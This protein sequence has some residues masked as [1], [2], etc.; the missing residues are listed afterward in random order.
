M[1]TNNPHT[2]Q[3]IARAIEHLTTHYREQPSLGELAEKANLSEFHFQRLFTEWAGVSPKKFSQYLTLEHAKSRLRNGAPLADAAD[4]AGLSGT[5]RLHD[6]FVT[7][8]GITPGQFKQGGSGLVLTYGIFASPFGTYL[9][10]AINDKI[11]LLHFLNEGDVPEIILTTAWPEASLRPDP[12]TLQ[13]LTDQIFNP[14]AVE[15]E[16]SKP[17]LSVLM[18][19]SAFQ[20]KV[21]EALLKIPEGGL[22]SYDQIA[23]AIGQPTASRAV[24][25][26]I[27]S[28]PVGYLIPC[29][30][31][32]KK[33][34]LFGGYRWGVE[35]KQA[36]LGWEAARVEP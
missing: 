35:R 14:I 15:H 20:L 9:L 13:P 31:V 4:A 22:A 29:H 1:N 32:I 10:G 19:G 3:Q 12:V 17:V 24:G 23:H 8:E 6:L 26:A 16:G 34:G 18:R 36:M 2:Y 28:N 33:T 25:T 5:G 30:R 7:I 27:G 11:A 21:W